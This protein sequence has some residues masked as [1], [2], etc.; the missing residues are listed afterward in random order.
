MIR[1]ESE[2]K[3]LLLQKAEAYRIKEKKKRKTLLTVLPVFLITVGIFTYFLTLYPQRPEE[4]NGLKNDDLRSDPRLTEL[5]ASNPNIRN[6]IFTITETEYVEIF[7]DP[8]SI[9]Y[10]SNE[11]ETNK[12]GESG[13]DPDKGE[14]AFVVLLSDGNVKLI[15]YRDDAYSADGKHWVSL[16][17]KQ[18]AFIEKIE[19]GEMTNDENQKTN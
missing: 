16:T 8:E 14:R 9:I 1:S 12:I 5:D 2:V 10:G 15:R 11:K 17:E 19:K 6:G 7:R 13:N 18:K 3:S 4:Q